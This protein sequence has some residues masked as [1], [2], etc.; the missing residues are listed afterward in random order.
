MKD[1]EGMSVYNLKTTQESTTALSTPI[2][3]HLDGKI[4]G[5]VFVCRNAPDER[6]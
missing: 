2:T 5:G 3:P 4:R 1:D 6:K